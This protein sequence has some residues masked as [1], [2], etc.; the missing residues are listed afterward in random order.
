MLRIG[1][2]TFINYTMYKVDF[3]CFKVSRFVFN[4]KYEVTDNTTKALI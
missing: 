1:D 3:G 2:I 4:K